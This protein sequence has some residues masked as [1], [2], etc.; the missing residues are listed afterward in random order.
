MSEHGSLDA[1]RDLIES[2]CDHFEHALRAGREPNLEA[3]LGQ[4]REDVRGPLR[5]ELVALKQAYA[6]PSGAAKTSAGQAAPAVILD[7]SQERWPER[8]GRFRIEGE[9][10]RGGMGVVL[11]AH[12]PELGRHVA[13]KTL[14]KRQAMREEVR[15][16]FLRETRIMASLEHPGV[17]PIH[18]TGRLD[19]GRPFFVMKLIQGQTLESLF[20]ERASAAEYHSRLLQVFEQVCETVAYAHSRGIIHRDL[21]PSNVMVGAFGEV[22]VMDW[23][24]AGARGED[25]EEAEE[26]D[27]AAEGGVVG[28]SGALSL[29]QAGS[30]FGTLAYM[31]PEQILGENHL[32]G[33][34]TDVFGLGAILFEMLVGSA[35]VRTSREQDGTTRCVIADRLP[36][37]PADLVSLVRECL[38][39]ARAD[40]PKGAKAVARRIAQIRATREEQA[41]RFQL[42]EARL[43]LA[44][45]L[46]EERRVHDAV[47][48]ARSAA[49]LADQPADRAK[50]LLQ[51]GDAYWESRPPAESAAESAYRAA[52]EASPGDARIALRICRVLICR[53]EAREA[54]A[55][56]REK[57][58]D[59]SCLGLAD[60]L[61]LGET[62]QH[63]GEH[64]QA[65]KAFEMALVRMTSSLPAEAGDSATSCTEHDEAIARIGRLARAARL[66][67]ALVQGL[68]G[69]GRSLGSLGRWSEAA[70]H[71]QTALDD[72]PDLF[73]IRACRAEIARAEGRVRE[74]EADCRAVLEKHPDCLPAILTLARSRADVGDLVGAW[75]ALDGK[76]TQDSPPTV[77]L[78][79]ASLSNTLARPGGT[80]LLTRLVQR[81]DVTAA[82]WY[83]LSQARL[84]YSRW[85]EALACSHGARG[86][87]SPLGS[88]EEANL[89]LHE[90]LSN[91]RLASLLPPEQWAARGR[92]FYSLDR[93]RVLLE[94][95]FER[96]AAPAPEQ[97]TPGVLGVLEAAMRQAAAS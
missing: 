95:G 60:L 14:Q 11:R 48:L 85:S 38:A 45:R 33:T 84:Q 20:R 90:Q 27:R 52:L 19:D 67:D 34:R 16:R 75:E 91:G 51:L 64:D 93:V 72:N 5:R 18:E 76:V 15:Q 22:Q 54:V 13:I 41:A 81:D 80:A 68:V 17:P 65:A 35:P 61:L 2:L 79:F 4:A 10:G 94:E 62:Y 1:D 87:G 6:E 24:L 78:L 23:G 9:I 66:R 42:M 77:Q 49:E 88:L 71:F 7:L 53:G 39:L 92:E 58:P 82:D 57:Q 73:E 12:D 43:Q 8:I 97:P 50:A 89:L 25:A 69:L 63:G 55:L 74:A 59:L 29:T 3:Y 40:R 32:I 26:E 86:L 46:L 30:V 28:S 56:L 21:K 47:S 96:L 37:A 83:E 70:R 31:A 44:G 36:E